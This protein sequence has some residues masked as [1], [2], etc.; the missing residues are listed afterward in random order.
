MSRW[1]QVHIQH[2]HLNLWQMHIRQNIWL[3]RIRQNKMLLTMLHLERENARK[4]WNET[5]LL[6]APNVRTIWKA[7]ARAY[8]W[9]ARRFGDAVWYVL[10]SFLIESWIKD[11]KK[12]RRKPLEPGLKLAIRFCSLAAGW[13]HYNVI[14]WHVT[15]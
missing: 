5:L 7:Y 1:L 9:G 12:W 11:H 2:L 14:F 3:M 8:E 6:R 10:W 13:R 15:K 4:R